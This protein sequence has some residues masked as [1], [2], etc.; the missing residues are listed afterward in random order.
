M[1]KR[2]AMSEGRNSEGVAGPFIMAL[3][4]E[5]GEDT[6][7]TLLCISKTGVITTPDYNVVLSKTF[8]GNGH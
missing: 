7:F 1:G 4:T 5:S 6:F 8:D 2:I 3:P